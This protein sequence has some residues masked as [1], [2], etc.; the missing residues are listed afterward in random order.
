MT[1]QPSPRELCDLA[2]KWFPPDIALRNPQLALEKAEALL[3]A[4]EGR[5]ESELEETK[6]LEDLARIE[7]IIPYQQRISLEEAYE[8]QESFDKSVYRNPKT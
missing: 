6:L 4:A 2:A 1:N 5:Q 8:Y 3:A 7:K